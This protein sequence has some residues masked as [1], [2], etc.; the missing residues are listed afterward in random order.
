MFAPTIRRLT[1]VT[2]ITVLGPEL[3]RFSVENIA[4]YLAFS[5]LAVLAAYFRVGIRYEQ[6]HIP[7]SL[8]FILLSLMN[9]EAPATLCLAAVTAFIV[10]WVS[11]DGPGRIERSLFAG[12]AM[13]IA[14]AMAQVAYVQTV[15]A[16]GVH[17]AIRYVLTASVL[18][19]GLTFP[20]TFVEA[21]EENRRMGPYWKERYLWMLPYYIGLTVMSALFTAA[22]EVFNGWQIPFITCLA[23]YLVYRSYRLY[24]GRLEDGRAHAEEV[25]SLHLRTIEALALAIDAKDETTHDHLQR[26]QVYAVEIGRELGLPAMQIE[27][28]R[29]ASLLHDIGKLA[30]P[31][32]IISKPGRLTAE[33]FEKMKIHPVV[34]AEILER[35]KF[36]YPV[37]PMVRSHHEKWDG[38]GYPDGLKGEEIPIG[39]RILSAVDCLDALCTDRQY[40][41]A[42]PLDRAIGVVVQEAGR[43]FDPRV[44]EVLARRY[45]E[46]ERMAKASVCEPLRLSKDLK[47]PAG[48]APAAGLVGEDSQTSMPVPEGAE[49]LQKIAAARQ[50][51]QALFELAQNLG[52]SLSIDETL[53]V[54][55]VR[56]RRLIPFDS[57]AVYIRR[58]SHL[59]PQFV[60]GDNMRLFASLSIPVGQGLSGWVAENGR[61]ILNGNPSVEPGYLNDPAK[62]STLRAALAVPLQGVQSI[63]GVLALYRADRDA[64]S[65][66]HLRILQAV[67]SK[68]ALAVENALKFKQAETSAVTDFLTGLPNARSLF[69]HLDAEIARCQSLNL[70]LAV[71]VCDVDNFKQINDELG[72]L[73]GNKALKA[74]ASTLVRQCRETDYAA[75]MGGDEFVLLLPGMPKD[76]I[77][78]R[79]QRMQKMVLDYTRAETGMP[80]SVSI[81]SSSLP[82]DGTDAES[83]LATADRSMYVSKG[84]SQRAGASL[85]QTGLVQQSA[86]ARTVN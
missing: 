19:L 86:A 61:P 36:P 18:F 28:V 51:A 11:R 16:G 5:I 31:E 74:V 84:V 4:Q 13:V 17:L 44:V 38:S 3:A 77:A 2:G 82:E 65:R 58:D 41:R 35:V 46:L 75:R 15:G 30:V 71:L 32:H 29:A 22:S 39:A 50:E 49:F 10:E 73:E 42:L 64:F 69:L 55:S 67:S 7:L 68:I 83:L 80:L 78:E 6:G 24:M 34:G 25:A 27:A 37:V 48:D 70:P 1:I 59:E 26:V 81:G 56:L 72:H 66:D 85:R 45:Q 43:S 52:S 62:F 53:S 33:E 12:S 57:M 23:G 40:R 60:S 9:I 14:I 21:S 79:I 47:V 8:L 20:A 63:V 76:R 54:V